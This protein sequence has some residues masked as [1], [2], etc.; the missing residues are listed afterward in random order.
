MQ[1]RLLAR[2]HLLVVLLLLGT[3]A[4]A[5]TKVISGKVTDAKDGTPLGGVSVI[6][7]GN[8]PGTTTDAAGSF[9]LTVPDSVKVLLFSFVGFTAQEVPVNAAN[10]KVSL[11]G[12]NTS[13]N[14]VIVIGYGSTR[15]KDLTG[16]VATVTAK[17]FQKGS[18]A[19]PEQLIAGKVPGVSI[20]SN[21]GQPGV[22]STIRIRGGA[23]LS[24][25]NDPLI[26]IDGVP[27]DNDPIAGA[28][29]PLSFINPNDIE[30]FTILK[31]ASAT[32]IYGTRASNGVI[33]ITRLKPLYHK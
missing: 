23:S 20:I 25:S 3:I 4:L 31:D 2:I 11:T 16:S 8:L 5:Q 18:I 15:K 14:E 26:V 19:S 27:L 32:A 33:I 24:A 9:R 1:K 22:G 30:S 6:P 21:G 28:G 12:I 7:R 10:L 13:L 29:S 17:D